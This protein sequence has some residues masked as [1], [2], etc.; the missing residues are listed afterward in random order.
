[1]A[2]LGSVKY[3]A[4]PIL[5]AVNGKGISKKETREH[6]DITGENN[7]PVSN[8]VHSTKSMKN[9]RNELNNLG[10]FAKKYH[11]VKDI[12]LIDIDIIRNWIEHKGNIGYRTA[13]NYLSNINKIADFL[14][15]DKA[16]VKILRNDLKFKL[17]EP[18]YGSRAYKKLEEMQLR[19][20]KSQLVFE[21]QREY[22]LRVTAASHINI[23]KQFD[24]ATFTYSE[25]G[26]MKNTRQFPMELIDRIKKLS[27]NG[28]FDV[29]YNTYRLHLKTVIEADNQ[30]FNGTHGI[31][32]SWAQRELK[33]RSPSE[34]AKD[35]GHSREYI[36]RT[37]LR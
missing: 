21:L 18:N 13:S 37:Y 17:S 11:S 16:D 3:Q 32:H 9:L 19:D 8:L 31:R 1:M 36:I 5:A 22:G 33:Y 15:V 29:P 30:V 12:T 35:M 20:E 14:S 26:G 2:K 4:R 28:R 25:K 7:K 24:N 34:V 23:D 6:S 10:N 27:V